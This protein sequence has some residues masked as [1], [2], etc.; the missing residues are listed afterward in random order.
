MLKEKEQQCHKNFLLRFFRQTA[1]G[2]SRQEKEWLQLNK[3][4]Y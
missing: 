2:P 1:P 4:I 3:K